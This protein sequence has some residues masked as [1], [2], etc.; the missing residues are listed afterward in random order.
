M[1]GLRHGKLAQVGAAGFKSLNA[2]STV[3]ASRSDKDSMGI[4]KGQIPW[5]AGGKH[6]TRPKREKAAVSR[7]FFRILSKML[8]PVGLVF[9]P[10]F[11]GLVISLK[12]QLV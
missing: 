2:I 5:P 9:R 4:A 11:S 1:K 7:R 6:L 10:A 3:A 8:R 12:T